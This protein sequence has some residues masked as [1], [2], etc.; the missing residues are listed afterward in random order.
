M[1]S[2]DPALAALAD[3]HRSQGVV[4][5]P[6]LEAHVARHTFPDG[7]FLG[8]HGEWWQGLLASLAAAAASGQQGRAGEGDS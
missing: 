3:P 5:R 8:R 4:R 7:L 2:L 6:V 1:A